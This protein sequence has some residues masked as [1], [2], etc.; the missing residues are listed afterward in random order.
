MLAMT[1]ASRQAALEVVILAVAMSAGF[2]LHGCASSNV[3]LDVDVML[4]M[5]HTPGHAILKVGIFCVAMFAWR[6]ICSCTCIN[7]VHGTNVAPPHAKLIPDTILCA[8]RATGDVVLGA[9]KVAATA[10]PARK[11]ILSVFI[12]GV[13]VQAWRLAFPNTVENMI[14]G[15][16][17]LLPIADAPLEAAALEVLSLKMAMSSRSITHSSAW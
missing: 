2:V 16:N 15:G 12:L 10:N 9:D 8:S 1:H 3:V 13:T 11:S 17:V 14:P 7:V 5:A 6:V 4:A